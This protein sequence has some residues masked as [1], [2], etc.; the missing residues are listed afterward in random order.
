MG[1]ESI[2]GNVALKT[3]QCMLNPTKKKSKLWIC[4][5]QP[6]PQKHDSVTHESQV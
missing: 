1:K 3:M 2:N 5:L 4:R 6:F